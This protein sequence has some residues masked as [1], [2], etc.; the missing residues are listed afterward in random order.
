[1]RQHGAVEA[2]AARGE[3]LGHG[4]R[5]QRKRRF[6]IGQPAAT[7]APEA[8]TCERRRASN[9]SRLHDVAVT[10]VFAPIGASAGMEEAPAGLADGPCIEPVLELLVPIRPDLRSCFVL[11]SC[12]SEHATPPS[13]T[14]ISRFN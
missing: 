7:E 10:L 12:C 8:R 3:R 9:E 4:Q 2:R 14:R 5:R 13:V 11:P 6:A 1:M